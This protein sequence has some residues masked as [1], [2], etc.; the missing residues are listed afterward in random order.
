MFGNKNMKLVKVL[1]GIQPRTQFPPVPVGKVKKP[2]LAACKM[3]VKE[4]ATA[5]I[6]PTYSLIKKVLTTLDK[7]TVVSSIDCSVSLIPHHHISFS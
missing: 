7:A 6:W 1:T 2:D 3:R 5:K 4:S